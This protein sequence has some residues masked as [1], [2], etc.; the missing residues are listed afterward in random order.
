VPATSPTDNIPKDNEP[1]PYP[2]PIPNGAVCLPVKKL[3]ELNGLEEAGIAY[4]EE[5][6]SYN[7]DYSSSI[8][9][10]SCN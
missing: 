4:Y 7:V 5:K 3:L 2:G 6:A 1:Y 10:R 9:Y 8:V